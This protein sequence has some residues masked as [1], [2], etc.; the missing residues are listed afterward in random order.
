[1]NYSEAIDFLFN[2]INS[3]QNQGNKAIRPGLKNIKSLCDHL[4]NPQNSYKIVH[5]GG[6]NGKGTSAYGISNICI[7][8]NLSVGLFTSPH[9]FDFRE[10]I[11][12]NGS[13]VEKNFIVDFISSN[14][15][16]IDRIS[17][18]FFEL[19]TAMAF[20]YFKKKCVDVAI[21]EVGLGGRLDSTNIVNSDVVL[22]T[23]IGLDHQNILGNSLSEIANEKAGIIKE[24]SIFIKGERQD[25][26]DH[27]FFNNKNKN[28]KSWKNL[29][30][31]TLKKNIGSRKY[32]IEFK[33]L[34]FNLDV[35]NPTNYFKNNIPGIIYT[36]YHILKKFSLDI[37]VNSF[38]GINKVHEINK[39]IS[40]WDVISRNPLIISDGCH[41]KP[42]FEMV[43]DEINSY[44]FSKVFFIIGGT[45]E[46]NWTEICKILP[47][48][49]NYIITE[50]NNDRSLSVDTF[51]KEFDKNHLNYLSFSSIQ[52]SL[53]F[54]KKKA[55]KKDLIFIG[56]SLFMLS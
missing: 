13:H 32:K 52:N 56:G 9:I 8:N 2:S 28:Y 33:N 44:N 17:P 40:R 10:R 14:K 18:S 55:K 54:C 45:K 26:I 39:I 24:N 25:E 1:M 38:D 20:E 30:L 48:N 29:R 53:N 27:I 36:S 11:Q 3:Y 51:K 50:P 46:K 23:N 21:I 47:S 4:N 12:V 42:S 15:N 34:K 7:H 41:N 37:N 16:I 5:V 19:T 35:L 49:F 6:T 43:I 22:I 31:K